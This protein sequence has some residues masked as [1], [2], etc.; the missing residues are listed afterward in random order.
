LSFPSDASHDHD[1]GTGQQ[2]QKEEEEEE[3]GGEEEEQPFSQVVQNVHR[4]SQ[5][6]MLTRHAE[7]KVIAGGIVGG[8]GGRKEGGHDGRKRASH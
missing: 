6:S 7:A 2:Q 1:N 4:V 5:R 3:G 8:R